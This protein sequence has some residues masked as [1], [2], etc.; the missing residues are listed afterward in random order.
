MRL[1]ERSG[2]QLLLGIA[3]T[4]PEPHG[5][6]LQAARGRFGDPMAAFIPPHITIIGPTAVSPEDVPLVAAHLTEVAA[7][8]APFQV[9][10]RGTGTFRPVSQVAFVQV[11]DGI[12]ACEQ[13]E[14][15][16]R[17]GPL[18]QELRFH[19]HPHVTVAHELEDAA[20]DEAID[21][22]TSFDATFVVQSLDCYEHGADGVWRVVRS[23]ALTGSGADAEAQRRA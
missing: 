10:L 2:D 17:S 12:S 4:V 16:A 6:V 15:A 7:S 18:A 9:R 21:E 20:L 11:A 22:L 19:Y 5:S 14:R 13:L 23:H 8:H 3:I 1:P